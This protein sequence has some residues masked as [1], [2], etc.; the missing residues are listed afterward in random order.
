MK[1]SK[2]LIGNE[3]QIKK[4]HDTTGISAKIVSACINDSREEIG[5]CVPHANV[6]FKLD[7][8]NQQQIDDINKKYGE[9]LHK[10]NYSCDHVYDNISYCGVSLN[11][12][13]VN[14][15][16]ISLATDIMFDVA[17][18]RLIE[19]DKINFAVG[20]ETIKGKYDQKAREVI[21]REVNK[22]IKNDEKLHIKNSDLTL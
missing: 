9:V 7:Y 22:L 2:V 17:M 8:N 1:K 4:G 16:Y 18:Q 21:H 20:K 12:S 6:M 10:D 11:G 13:K 19:N 14:Y 3:T 5:D 15:I